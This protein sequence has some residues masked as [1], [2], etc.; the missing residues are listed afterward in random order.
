MVACACGG[1]SSGPA[2]ANGTSPLQEAAQQVL[3]ECGAS[4]IG[5]LLE[6]LEI[7]EGLLDP[8]ETNPAQF[9]DIVTEPSEATVHWGLDLG[10]DPLPDLVGTFRFTDDLGAPEPAADVSSLAGGFDDLDVMIASLPDGTF[11]NVAA[12][13]V[14]PPPFD[15]PLTFTIVGGTVDTVSGSVSAHD[16]EA[17]CLANLDFTD[18]PFADVGGAYPSLTLNISLVTG[19]GGVVGTIVFDGTNQ[20]RAEV[21]LGEEAEV[22]A[23]LIDLDTGTVTPTQ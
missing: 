12:G 4:S 2:P 22:Y 20:A 17:D 11:L 7:F 19:E 10:G 14:E 13:R 21:T 16:V 9:M 23:F 18:V 5:D 15:V 6:L 3:E 8:N 1:G